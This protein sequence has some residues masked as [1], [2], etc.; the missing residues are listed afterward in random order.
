[1]IKKA[2]E[3][4][5]LPM[6]RNM[7]MVKKPSPRGGLGAL[8][9][10]KKLIGEPVRRE[11]L[12][13]IIPGFIPS[14]IKIPIKGYNPPLTVSLKYVKNEDENNGK[15]YTKLNSSNIKMSV[16]ISTV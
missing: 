1:M 6:F 15:I 2:P 5:N 8:D 12:V 9:F 13:H 4:L 16:F 10:M 7:S 14:F 11:N 3:A